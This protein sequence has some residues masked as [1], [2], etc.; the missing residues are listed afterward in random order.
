MEPRDLEDREILRPG[1][2]TWE[3][4]AAFA[5]DVYEGFQ[6]RKEQTVAVV[7]YLEDAYNRVQFKPLMDFL[8]QYRVSL[9]L[10]RKRTWESAA[11]FAYDVYEGFQLRKKKKKKKKKKSGCGNRSREY[12]QQS[13]VQAADGLSHAIWSHANIDPV[14]FSSAHEKNGGYVAW[15]LELCSSSAHNVPTARITALAGPLQCI[16][17]RPGRSEPKWTQQD[18]YAGR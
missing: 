1:K 15:K 2:G 3:N 13:P 8:V 5:Y 4:V 6:L 11:A 16:H 9:I 10:S 18:S 17:Q 14:D 12:L 7:I